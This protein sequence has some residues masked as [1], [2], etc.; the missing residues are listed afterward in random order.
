MKPK[1]TRSM[2]GRSQTMSHRRRAAHPEQRRRESQ[3]NARTAHLGTSIMCKCAPRVSTA[4]A[5]IH[6]PNQRRNL[7]QSALTGSS[8]SLIWIFD[9]FRILVDLCGAIGADSGSSARL[10]RQLEPS[11][12]HAR[13]PVGGAKGRTRQKLPRH[14]GVQ[15]K[16]SSGVLSPS[17]Y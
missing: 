4:P 6:R 16:R 15:H 17:R 1:D 2:P 13:T 8:F 11:L 12:A 5:G 14:S 9:V 7:S 3:A 10:V